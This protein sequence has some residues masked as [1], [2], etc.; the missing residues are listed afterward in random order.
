M[1]GLLLALDTAT[2]RIALALGRR[3]GG[4]VEMIASGDFDAPRQALS[5]LVPAAL[6]MLEREGLEPSRLEEIIVGR[7]PGSFTGVRIGVATAKGL[8]HGLGVPLH[9]VGTLDAVAWRSSAYEGLIGVLGDAMRKEVYPA[10]FRASGGAV[11]RL[12]A[13]SVA[14]PADVAARWGAL[15]EPVLVTGNGLAKYRELFDSP[16]TGLRIADPAVWAPTGAGLLAAFQAQVEAGSV[17]DGSPGGLLP[18][19]TRLSDA[20]ENERERAGSPAMPDSGVEG[21]GGPGVDAPCGGGAL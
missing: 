13:D 21:P 11:T 3:E 9:G 17:D 20:E 12:E 19:Y 7:G 6:A 16:Q 5:M 10:L 4:R 15:G 14:S 18:I 2:E 1:S 8:A